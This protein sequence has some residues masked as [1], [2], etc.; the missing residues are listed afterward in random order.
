MNNVF[1]YVL[2][3]ISRLILVI[4]CFLQQNIIAQSLEPQSERQY[5]LGGYMGELGA[6]VNI[7]SDSNLI[8][9]AITNG[10]GGNIRNYHSSSL[11]GGINWDVWIIKIDLETGDTIWISRAFGGSGLESFG[12]SFFK[13]SSD[14]HYIFATT[15]TSTDGDITD[16]FGNGLTDYDWWTFKINAETG[17]PIW[18]S[19]AFGGTG[20]EDLRHFYIDSEGNVILAGSTDSYNGDVTGRIDSSVFDDIWAVKVNGQTGA[21]IWESP[22]LGGTKQESMIYGGIV[23]AFNGD[24]I[25]YGETNS[26]NGD[27]RNYLN[28]SIWGNIWIIR[29]DKNS[30]DTV[31]TSRALGGTHVDNAARFAYSL[32][33]SNL[34][35]FCITYSID[36]DVHGKHGPIGSDI[37]IIK[38]D[39]STGDTIWTSRGIGGNYN[40]G[41]SRVIQRSDDRYLIIGVTASTNGDVRGKYGSAISDI[42]LWMLEFDA[43]TLDTTWT[44][45]ALGG[46]R[47]EI[48]GVG[49]NIG[50]IDGDHLLIPV[51]TTS[52]NGD[53]TGAFSNDTIVDYDMWIVKLDI[54]TKQIITSNALNS[55]RPEISQGN[56]SK[57]CDGGYYWSGRRILKTVYEYAAM[58]ITEINIDSFSEA[59]W[60][61]KL[62]ENL[63]VEW[64]KV[65]TDSGGVGIITGQPLRNNKFILLANSG[66]DGIKADKQ[67]VSNDTTT[68][69]ENGVDIWAIIL[70]WQFEGT[71]I[72]NVGDTSCIGKNIQLTYQTDT[73]EVIGQTWYF[74]DGNSSFEKSPFHIYNQAGNYEISLIVNRYCKNNDTIKYPMMIDEIILNLGNDTNQCYTSIIILDAGND[75]TEY[76]WNTE[77]TTQIISTTDTGSFSVT[78]NNNISGCSKSD[79]IKIDACEEAIVFIPNGYSPN[80]IDG[81][82]DELCISIKYVNEI[83]ID[84][85]DRR[86]R[87]INRVTEKDLLTRDQICINLS[88]LEQKII[89]FH[90]RYKDNQD[91]W[92]FLKGN[93][94]LL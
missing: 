37:W 33:D 35:F 27:V 17:E 78:V 83:E 20:I 34:L 24:I 41:I 73:S 77:N 58:G 76:I 6:G 65:L 12:A 19:E 9:M 45:E 59:L 11:W 39:F 44:S 86:G 46:T 23:E 3:N 7:V 75:G 63:N 49:A 21:T 93:I 66:I 87:Q 56:L 47:N 89:V 51:N 61:I 16:K 71:I 64:E 62:D 32:S 82:N 42:D 60:L 15:T 13:E 25:L 67:V 31:W 38:I 18:F 43:N 81:S 1:L 50:L 74:G 14:G 90:A 72:S 2:K 10:T 26:K 29:L 54:N 28:D 57:A 30:G 88:F 94:S 91:N 55:A 4:F 70:S 53:V 8:I 36:G 48:T 40:D 84:F 5:C 69:F 68:N 79:T 92:K 52:K 80:N 22:A 85:Y